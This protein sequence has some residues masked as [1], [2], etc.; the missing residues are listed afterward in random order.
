[1]KDRLTPYAF[2]SPT[3]LLMLVLMLVPI[4]MVIVYSL[5][6]NVIMRKNSSFIGLGNFVEVLTD[7][8][9]RTAL[10]NTTIFT[11]ASVDRPPAPGSRRSP[12]C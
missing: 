8:T 12:C 7:K 2:L 5:Q 10:V 11:V 9:F 4:V 3:V 1:M 6:D